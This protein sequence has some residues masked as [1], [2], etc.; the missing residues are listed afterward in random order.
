MNGKVENW[1]S[2][3]HNLVPVQ[4]PESC[5]ECE[6]MGCKSQSESDRAWGWE[7]W[8]PR[9]GGCPGSTRE[10]VHPLS[11]LCP[12]QAFRA[13]R[14]GEGLHSALSPVH[15]PLWGGFQES[16]FTSSV[17]ISYPVKFPD[18]V[19]HRVSDILVTDDAVHPSPYWFSVAGSIHSWQGSA[20]VSTCDW[21]CLFL[22]TV[23]P[24]FASPVLVFG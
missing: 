21:I 7:S 3:W 2:W 18:T 15:M 4:R 12:L 14:T 17:H 13:H 5:Q 16:C 9:T 24:V 6:G 11:A 22:V 8:W 1:E 23:L 20:E 10:H 19:A